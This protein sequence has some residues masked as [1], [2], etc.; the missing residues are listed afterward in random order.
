MPTERNLTMNGITG[1]EV[2]LISLYEKEI[3]KIRREL[4][5]YY[6]SKNSAHLW[7][8]LT[9][10]WPALSQSIRTLVKIYAASLDPPGTTSIGIQLE[11]WTDE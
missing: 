7:A 9:S 11:L 8:K 5:F 6:Q 3:K 2:Y 10:H 1:R 4:D